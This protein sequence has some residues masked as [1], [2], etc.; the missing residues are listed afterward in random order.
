MSFE[1]ATQAVIAS[2]S[3]EQSEGEAK[4]S[5]SRKEEIASAEKRRLAMTPAEQLRFEKGGLSDASD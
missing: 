1:V 4:Q 5:P 2:R 3:P